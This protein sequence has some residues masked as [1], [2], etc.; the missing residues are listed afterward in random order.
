MPTFEQKKQQALQNFQNT[1]AFARERKNKEVEQFLQETMQRLAEEKLIVVVCGEFKQGKSSFINAFLNEPDLCPVDIDIATSL[2]TSITYAPKEQL[3]VLLGEPGQEIKQEKRL[4]NRQEIADYVTEQ[5][6]PGNKRRARLL[7]VQTP[8]EQLKSGMVLVDTPGVGGLNSEHTDISYAFLPSADVVL[9]VSDVFKPL[10]TLEIDFIKDRIAPSCQNIIFIL[11]KKDKREDYQVIL[12]D[13]RQKLAAALQRPAS[14]IPIIPVSSLAK[15]DYLE[16]HDESDLQE[17]NFP[18]LETYLWRYLEEGRGRILLSRAANALGKSLAELRLPIQ[19][20]LDACKEQDQQRLDEMEQQV[21][22]SQQRLQA[23]LENNAQWQTRLRDGLEDVQSKTSELFTIGFRKIKQSID[24]YV[25]DNQLRKQPELIVNRLQGDISM[26]LTELENY[27]ASEATHLQ[28]ELEDATGLSLHRYTSQT[29]VPAENEAITIEAEKTDLWQKS[30]QVAR[31]STFTGLGGATVVGV[32]GG[33]AGAT[34]GLLT[35]GALV[36]PLAQLGATLGGILGQLAGSVTGV[37]QGIQQINKQ[38]QDKIARKLLDFVQGQETQQIIALRRAIKDL[39]RSLRDDLL[40]QL[41]R[42]KKSIE[43]ALASL[44]N[45]RK[46]TQEQTKARLTSLTTL[47]QRVKQ[48]EHGVEQ[49]L[50]AT[51]LVDTDTIA[52]EQRQ[53]AAVSPE[54]KD[55]SFGDWADE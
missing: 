14:E 49:M 7:A 40:A 24:T 33:V 5:G 48:L 9:F 27:I 20:E 21:R 16:S 3:T 53:P 39:E 2:V 38:E 17:S 23:L 34:L 42:E 26:L 8:N 36:I 50:R 22:S 6:N 43:E 46:L 12:D 41:T 18:K 37:R 28:G 29:L 1:I 11:T 54:K 44:L 51:L 47:L 4:R 31:N 45:A 55:C 15:R 30:L 32:I 35:G 13:N 25:Q 52:H 10:T 19:T